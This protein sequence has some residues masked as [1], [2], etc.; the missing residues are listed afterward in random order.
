M[1]SVKCNFSFIESHLF[2]IYGQIVINV[3]AKNPESS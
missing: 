3:E 1:N 2:N